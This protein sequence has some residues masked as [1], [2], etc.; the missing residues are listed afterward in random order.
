MIEIKLH[1][2]TYF[3]PEQ[4]GFSPHYWDQDASVVDTISE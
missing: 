2:D 3:S 1:M 4:V